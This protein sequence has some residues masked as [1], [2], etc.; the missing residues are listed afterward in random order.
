MNAVKTTFL[1]AVMRK[2]PPTQEEQPRPYGFMSPRRRKTVYRV[3]VQT[4]HM[5]EPLPLL[6]PKEDWHALRIKQLVGVR[7]DVTPTAINVEIGDRAAHHMRQREE[8]KA[9][10]KIIP[11]HPKK[12]ITCLS[13][14][15]TGKHPT[16]GTVCEKCHG[17]KEVEVDDAAS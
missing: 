5:K 7:C 1:G 2:D 17:E 16:L 9:T 12:K 11:G 3:W 10:M 13:C 6:L 4:F 14:A 15:G 8:P